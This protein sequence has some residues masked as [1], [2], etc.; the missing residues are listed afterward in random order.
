MTSSIFWPRRVLGLCSPSAHRIASATLDLPQPFGPTMQVMPGRT[1]TSVRSAND[2]KPWRTI[3][4]SRMAAPAGANYCYH[5]A[6]R[7]TKK[8]TPHVGDRAG[9]ATRCRRRVSAAVEGV[10]LLVFLAGPA[11]ARV[12]PSDFGAGGKARLR[13]GGGARGGEVG[14]PAMAFLPARPRRRGHS[15]GG[16]LLPDHAH[17]EELL[18][19]D[20]LEVVHHLLEHIERFLLV[21]GQRVALAVTAEADTLLEMVHAQEMILPQLVDA[22][23]LPVLPPQP[24]HDPALEAVEHLG[25]ELTLALPVGLLG[26]LGDLRHQRLL[27]ADLGDVE[28]GGEPEVELTVEALVQRGHVPGL[29]MSVLGGVAADQGRD[30][31]ADPLQHRLF[32]TLALEN[33]AAHPVDDL[34]LLVHHVV[35]LEE[36]FPDLEVAGLHALLRGADGA[37]HHRVLDGLA[38]LHSEPIH[39]ALDALGA[40]DAEEIVLE[41]EV[42]ARGAGVALPAGAA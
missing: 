34:A 11:G 6:K 2:L 38:L 26:E 33:L 13:A 20:L 18:Q 10:A 1:R 41:R 40:E 9:G 37:S 31:L 32:L 15:D 42:E 4:S 12:V 29:G 24:Q 39:D 17:L 28:I 27:R 25:S 14:R 22:P 8:K 30:H 35:V 3:C 5:T 19:H 7:P 23:E 21:L 36:V 16:R